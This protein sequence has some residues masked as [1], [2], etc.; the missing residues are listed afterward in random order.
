ME[1]GLTADDKLAYRQEHSKPIV[2]SFFDWVKAQRQRQKLVNSNPLSK[3]LTY[4]T[5]RERAMRVFLDDPDVQLDTNHLERQIRYIAMGKKSCLFCWSEVGAKQVGIIESLICS[6]KLQGVDPTTH[7]IDVLQRV[8]VHLASQAEDLIPRNWK[9]K[10]ADN[11]MR[12]DL[13]Q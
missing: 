10:F 8:A 5:K 2:D 12:S 7:L 11:P 9:E 3:A 6:C 4:A 1:L 13:D